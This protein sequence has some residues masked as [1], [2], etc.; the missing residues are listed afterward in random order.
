[1]SLYI[2]VPVIPVLLF[3]YSKTVMHSADSAMHY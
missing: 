2:P 1:M 3:V